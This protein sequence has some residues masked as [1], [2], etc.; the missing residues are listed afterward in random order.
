MVGE[1]KCT[2]TSR[3]QMP[4]IE[5]RDYQGDFEDV[6]DLTRR[7]WD[8]EYRG[9]LW[10]PVADAA[11][12][13]WRLSPA[14][15]AVCVV[16]YEGS[17][18]VGTIF[19]APQPMRVRDKVITASL[20]TMFTVDPDYRRAALPLVE[21]MQRRNGAQGVVLTLGLV[22]GDPQSSS[23]QFW[24][25]FAQAFP[26]KFK[27][28]GRG[29]FLAKFLSPSRL[30]RAGINYTERLASRTLGP[31]LQLTPYGRDT[32]VRPYRESDIDRCVE[33]LGSATAMFEW[34]LLWSREEFA[35]LVSNKTSETFV[36]E[37]DGVV[38][39]L[40]HYHF[41]TI[42]GR[43]PVR[44]AMLDLWAD[45]GL[46]TRERMR[47]VCHLCHHLCAQ[48]VHLLAAPRTGTL[49]TA[50]FLASLFVPMPDV[51]HIG[52]HMAPGFQDV[53]PPK[54]WSIVLT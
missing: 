19:S 10:F 25:K 41:L 22:L 47:F 53:S 4:D 20:S 5:I 34:A 18:M 13:S 37:R 26:S 48:D 29:R 42:Q 2:I 52:I 54:D 49:P 38:Q 9:R 30:A 33:V 50:A 24:S 3:V 8:R 23:F 32:H 40:A 46:T 39:G 15:R 12:L 17:K 31:L 7:V 36:F 43:E 51:V 6:A 45:N 35:Y 1:N 16:A 28:V 44:G 11:Y 14:C 27:F 21:E